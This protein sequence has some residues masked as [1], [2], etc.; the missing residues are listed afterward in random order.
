MKKADH[1]PKMA[2][3]KGF[4]FFKICFLSLDVKVELKTSSLC[5]D[6][7]QKKNFFDFGI[8][9]IKFYDPK[10]LPIETFE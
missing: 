7:D 4:F 3:Y 5:P 9:F 8:K 1:P 10:E 2:K 6:V